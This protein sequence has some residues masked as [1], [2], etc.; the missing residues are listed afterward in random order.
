MSIHANV[1]HSVSYLHDLPFLDICSRFQV[2]LPSQYQARVE[3]IRSRFS[4][5]VCVRENKEFCVSGI[6]YERWAVLRLT[7]R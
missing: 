5:G 3:Y 4:T 7:R 2:K 1:Q 6:E